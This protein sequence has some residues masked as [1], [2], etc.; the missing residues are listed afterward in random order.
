MRKL[1]FAT[2]AVAMIML[3]GFAFIYESGADVSGMF[4][5]KKMGM[6]KMALYKMGPQYMYAGMVVW[7]GLA[8]FWL[9]MLIDC[10]ARKFKD[11]H[12]KIVWVFVLLFAHLLGAILYLF[13]VKIKKQKRSWP[14]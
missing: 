2:F 6:M 1:M 3:A 8:L 7:I 5:Y 9:W 10:L 11:A 13:M 14:W 12:D 4:G